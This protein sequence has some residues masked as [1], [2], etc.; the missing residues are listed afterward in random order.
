MAARLPVFRIS[1][2]AYLYPEKVKDTVVRKQP[3]EPVRQRYAYEL[4]CAYGIGIANIEFERP[5]P[6]LWERASSRND[7]LVSRSVGE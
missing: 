1:P 4:I 5:G 6:P 2:D 3:E 7:R